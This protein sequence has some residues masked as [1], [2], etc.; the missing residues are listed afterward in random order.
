MS[1]IEEI[2]NSFNRLYKQ[3]RD[4]YGDNNID[5]DRSASMEQALF[6]LL[7]ALYVWDKEEQQI[8]S[9][10]TTPSDYWIREHIKGLVYK[11]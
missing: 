4:D 1:I 5:N 8:C 9:F 6:H 3:Y 10:S 2:N 7:K 11:N